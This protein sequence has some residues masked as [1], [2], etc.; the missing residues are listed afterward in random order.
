MADLVSLMVIG[1]RIVKVGNSTRRSRDIT[2]ILGAEARFD[3]SSATSPYHR[4]PSTGLLTLGAL[5]DKCM[6]ST[7][8]AR[9]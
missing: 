6:L 5:M 7:R 4:N 3:V 8:R 9:R 1:E 2:D